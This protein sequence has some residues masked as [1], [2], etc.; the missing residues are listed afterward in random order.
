MLTITLKSLG[1]V[2]I[3]CYHKLGFKCIQLFII[4]IPLAQ[5]WGAV[6]QQIIHPYYTIKLW[7]FVLLILKSCQQKLQQTTIL[8]FTFF[9]SKKIRLDVSCVSP[10]RGFT[11]N[12]KSYCLWKTKKKYSWMSSTAV[13]FGTLMVN[14][15]C[16]NVHP[17]SSLIWVCTTFLFQVHLS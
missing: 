13:L 9:L 4:T 6:Y 17:H 2:Q 8:F 7:N 1:L 11:W 10:S 16:N 15:Y 5:Y 14:V 3:F 12:I